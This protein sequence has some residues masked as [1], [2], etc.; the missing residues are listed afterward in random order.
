MEVPAG[1]PNR[2][3]G[4]GTVPLGLA[5]RGWNH[6]G[7]PDASYDGHYIEPYQRDSGGAKMYRVQAPR[8]H[9][10][11]VRARALARRG[12]QQLVGRDHPPTA[13]GCC[14][15]SGAR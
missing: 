6:V 3:T 4:I 8:R 13:S 15:A 2:Y 11:G 14:P 7:D 12:P 10:V 5:F 9:L 1:S